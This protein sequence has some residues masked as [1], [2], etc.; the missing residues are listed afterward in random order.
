MFRQTALILTLT[1]LGSAQVHAIN[2]KYA[3]QLERSGCT[4]VTEA[5]GCDIHK[6]KAENAKAGF[7][8]AAPAD[9]G[10][11]N[12]SY[13]QKLERSGCTQVSELS[14]CDINKS[15]AENAAAGFGAAPAAASASPYTGNWVAT[16]PETGATVA[17][18]RIDDKD[19][20]WVNDKQVSARKSDGPWCS[21]RAWSPIASRG[22][23]ASREK[24]AGSTTTPAPRGPS[25]PN[26]P[27]TIPTRGAE[28]PLVVS[29][30]LQPTPPLPLLREVQHGHHRRA[31]RERRP[32]GG[33]EGESG[34]GAGRHAS[35]TGG[36]TMSQ[37]GEGRIMTH[38][39]HAGESI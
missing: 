39:Q 20:V 3:E 14:G 38:Q 26:D 35:D 24:M 6:S 36:K 34:D 21:R 1:L 8:T 33:I 28:A 7:G 9:E 25:R 16:F 12:M 11:L 37:V 15:K 31:G 30:C 5:Q 19:Q 13:E 2:H 23:A 32:G 22:I 18:I 29:A 27:V 10:G 4:Q 17:N